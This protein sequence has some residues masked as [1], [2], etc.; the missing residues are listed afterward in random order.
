MSKETVKSSKHTVM[1]RLRDCLF[2]ASFIGSFLAAQLAAAATPGWQ[3][4]AYT[5]GTLTT[6]A[7]CR[8]DGFFVICDTNAPTYDSTNLRIGINSSTPVAS[9]DLSQR[10][11]AVALPVG[12]TATRPVTGVANGMIRYNTDTKQVEAYQN[13]GWGALGGGSATASGTAGSVQFTNGTTLNNNYANFFWDN[14]NFRLGLGTNAPKSGLDVVNGIAVGTYAGVSG[15]GANNVI[16]S[17]SVS[18][19]TSSLY[20]P[21]LLKGS[22][23][24]TADTGA[25][26]SGAGAGLKLSYTTGSPAYGQVF[27]YD[28]GASAVKNLVLQLPGGNVGIGTNNPL[29]ALD[30]TSTSSAFLPPRITNAQRTAIASPVAG[31]MIYNTDNAEVEVYNGTAWAGVGSNIMN[32]AIAAFASASCPTGWSEYTTARGAFLRGIDNGAGLDPDGTRTAGAYQ[33]DAFAS[34]SHG[35]TDPGHTH[36]ISDPKHSHSI[37]DQSHNHTITDP[38]HIHSYSQATN[39]GNFSGGGGGAYNSNTVQDT[40]S[41]TTGISLAA[42]YTGITGTN[43]AS[44]GISVNSGT[45]GITMVAAGGAETRPKN[46]AVT[47]CKYNG[48]NGGGSAA[49]L[50]NLSDVTL[51]ALTNGQILTYN[52]TKWTNTVPTFS[53]Q[54]TTTGSNIYYSTGSVG[55]GTSGI[56]MPLQI[57]ADLTFASAWPVIGFNAYNNGSWKYLTTNSSSIVFQDYTNGGLNFNVAASGSAGSAISYV[58]GLF[59]KGNGNIGINTT[60]PLVPLDF[61]TA[62]NTIKLALYDGGSSALYGMGASS[63]NLTFGANIAANATPQMVLNSSGSV[64]IGTTSPQAS[65]DVSSRSDAIALP[66]G[67]TASRPSVLVPG[68]LRYNSDNLAVEI[69]QNGSWAT[70]GGAAWL[71]NGSSLY[72]NLGSVG[73]GT[74]VPKST[75]SVNGGA[76]IGATY[77]G[78]NAAGSNNLIVQGSVAIGT[79]S[80]T[81]PLTVAGSVS[82]TTTDTTVPVLGIANSGTATYGG[83]FTANNALNAVGVYASAATGNYGVYGTSSNTGV[84]GSGGTYGVY[85]LGVSVSGYFKAGAV[86]ATALVAQGTSGQTG[87]IQTWQNSGGTVLDTVVSN[88]NVGLGTTAPGSQLDINGVLTMR[89]IG[90]PS[91]SAT[92]QGTFYYDSTAQAFKISM[93]G[94]P[95]TTLSGSGGS[96]TVSSGAAGTVAYYGT[97]GTSVSSASA[98]TYAATGT[99]LTV[100]SQA[101]SNIPLAV[102]GVPAQTGDLQEWQANGGSV[103]AKI[104]STGGLIIPSS[105]GNL[106]VGTASPASDAPLEIF[107]TSAGTDIRAL[108]YNNATTAGTQARYDLATGTAN[109]YAIMGLSDNAGSPYMQYTVGTAVQ[110]TFYDTPIHIFRNQSGTEWMRITSGNIGIGT[111]APATYAGYTTL[112]L[113]NGTSGGIFDIMNGATVEGRLSADTGSVG[114]SAVANIPL[115]FST[116]SL[117]RMRITNAGSVGIGTSAPGTTLDMNGALTLRGIGTPALSAAGQG[118]I[119]YDTTIN[120]FKTSV[121]GQAYT[122]LGGSST[123]A[124]GA[125]NIY[126]LSSVSIGTTFAVTPLTVLGDVTVAGASANGNIY[127]SNLGSAQTWDLVTGSG[128]SGSFSVYDSTNSKNAL[129]VKASS[130]NVGIGTT[131][132]LGTLQVGTDLSFGSGWPRVGFNNYWNG[133]T[134][135]YLTTNSSSIIQQDYASGGLGFWTAPTGAAGS[136]ASVTEAM[137]IAGSGSVGIGTTSPNATLA[138][139]GIVNVTGAINQNGASIGGISGVPTFKAAQSY[140]ASNAGWPAF[141]ANFT[142]PK[143]FDTTNSYNASTGVFTAPIAGYYVFSFSISGSVAS[144]GS[145]N[146]IA[147]SYNGS[148][149]ENV[150]PAQTNYN[151][152]TP[153][154]GSW[155]NWANSTP[156]YLNVNDTVA[157]YKSCCS[158]SNTVSAWRGMFSGWYLH[159]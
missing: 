60:G 142:M 17:G 141:S 111:S 50:A 77:A 40:S 90:T 2:A 87:P 55:I 155:Y 106:A 27:A 154:A 96:G 29:A 79:S 19:G 148:V 110:K 86:T 46:V 42:S 85:A 114:L 10:S 136:T 88:G 127:L 137:F 4:F 13:N 76:A 73:I 66:S 5:S 128:A 153:Y 143:I 24:I 151:A 84:Y 6:G 32:G 31:M 75:L 129:T 53:S 149:N 122:V 94:A 82:A 63:G 132:P 115:L 59:L 116:N 21:L 57:G 41:S 69:Y 133:S 47:F 159:P 100:T 38:G 43:P 37:T 11:D 150:F 97:G 8:S 54:W 67:N 108:I 124:S 9:I 16:V 28:Y 14:T 92:G 48:V 95:Y 145:L 12:A 3:T 70:V 36:G 139:N 117:E 18:I 125:G 78:T 26:A 61:G 109:S 99:L 62:T 1:R 156:V 72:Y 126:N 49:A 35:L 118:I 25:L 65:L 81:V 56:N 152:Y 33:A 140:V 101:A 138:V 80:P 113:S 91:L 23:F 58:T 157:I 34:H 107:K 121:N 30:V 7:I 123:W 98:V 131:N 22:E 103:L 20:A 15:A 158:T 134:T 144:T 89:G 112:A 146:D 68:M 105:S 51:A 147:L 135:V 71:A 74:N 120:N 130:E 39:H 104:A 52:G 119:Y 93:N 64:A 102:V 83:Y 44:T 45:T